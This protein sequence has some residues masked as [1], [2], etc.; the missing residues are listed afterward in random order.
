MIAK[1]KTIVVA[2]IDLAVFLTALVARLAWISTLENSIHW[3]DEREFAAIA[4][5]LAA[6]E[7]YVSSS[8]QANPTVAAYL[9]LVFRLFGE[10]YVVARIGQCLM[11]AAA[12]VFVRRIAAMLV[13]PGA[14][15]FSGFLLALY[16]PHI[17]KAANV[18]LSLWR[19]LERML[20]WHG[21]KLI[22]VARH[23]GPC[24][25]ARSVPVGAIQ[26]AG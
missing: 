19:R 24:S 15:L 3:F 22:A 5:H 9:G 8:F 12:C 1:L 13:G 17:L 23:A 14:G 21:A 2:H 7:G 18:S 10:N 4:R 20:P 6:G 26:A 11:G 25:A 16:P